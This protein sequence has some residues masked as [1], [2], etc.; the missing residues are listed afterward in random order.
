MRKVIGAINMTLDGYCDHTAGII[1]DEELHEHYAK[2]IDDAGLLLYGRI[3]YGLMQ[4]W[5]TLL[6][7]PAEEQS[8]NDFA[9]S[10]DRTEKLVFSHTLK[11]TGW[12]SATLADGPLIE[13]VKQLKQQP[14][15]DILVGSR[16][17]IIQLLQTG[18]MDEFQLCIHPVIEGK[19]LPLFE[20]INDRTSLKLVKTKS[21]RTG[22][23]VCYYE[24]GQASTGKT[25]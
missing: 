6:T 1:A 9:I 22:A 14:G 10:I 21:L 12:S 5:Q 16:S 4:F 23:I 11:D 7:K 24:P 13:T 20:Q 8:L 3:T 18:V 15:K 2:L 25:A 19:G 17:L